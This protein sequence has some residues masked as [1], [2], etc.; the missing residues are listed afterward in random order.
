MT[1]PFRI[2]D[3]LE[4]IGE[5]GDTDFGAH[6]LVGALEM[7]TVMDISAG[8]EEIRRMILQTAQR[9]DLGEHSNDV[10]FALNHVERERHRHQRLPTAGSTE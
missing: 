9:V 7:L 1:D 10:T 3:V 2:I 8:H 5:R 4:T 6:T